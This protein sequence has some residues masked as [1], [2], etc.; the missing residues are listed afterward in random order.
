[1]TVKI[2]VYMDGGMDYYVATYKDVTFV[3]INAL[4][5]Q[6]NILRLLI[7][8][9]GRCIENTPDAMTS[10]GLKIAYIGK[11]GKIQLKFALKRIYSSKDMYEKDPSFVV[12]RSIKD[13]SKLTNDDL[14]NILY[15]IIDLESY[16]ILIT[17]S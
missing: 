15:K 4:P 9:Y 2:D 1:M 6:Y 3:E 12:S 10:K 5:K 16:L 7:R 8:F 13:M 11:K 14:E 17:C